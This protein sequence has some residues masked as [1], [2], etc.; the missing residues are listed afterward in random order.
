MNQFA[1]YQ[2]LTNNILTTEEMLQKDKTIRFSEE[3]IHMKGGQ[4]DFRISKISLEQLM[5]I[6]DVRR[7]YKKNKKMIIK[8][9]SSYTEVTEEEIQHI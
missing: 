9:S 4:C 6:L 5:K 7:K 1:S 8:Q 2:L 3:R